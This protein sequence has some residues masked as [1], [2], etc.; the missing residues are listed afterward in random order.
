M[1]KKYFSLTDFFWKIVFKLSDIA[2]AL[3]KKQ[4]K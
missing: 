4:K 3:E 2:E 1:S